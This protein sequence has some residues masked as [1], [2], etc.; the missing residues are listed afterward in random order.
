MLGRLWRA[1]RRIARVVVVSAA[2]S[3]LATAVLQ[4]LGVPALVTAL[5]V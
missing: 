3:I 5:I 4:R 2:V 1:A